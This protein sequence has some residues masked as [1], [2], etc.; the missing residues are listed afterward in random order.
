MFKII[1]PILLL[2]TSGLMLFMFTNPNYEKIQAKKVELASYNEALDNSKLILGQKDKL[3]SIVN[4]IPEEQKLK[5]EKLLPSNI[6]NI[7]LI[8]EIN[9]IAKR[10]GVILRAIEF[11]STPQAVPKTAIGQKAPTNAPD[12]GNSDYGTVTLGFTMV[13]SYPTCVSFLKEIETSLRLV[14]IKS[15]IFDAPMSSQDKDLYTFRI[16]LNTFWLK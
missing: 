13:A 3:L 16:E 2:G 14:E 8:L 9:N 12:L 11:G 6:D 1:F 15:V 4:E 10:Y 5:L 7:R